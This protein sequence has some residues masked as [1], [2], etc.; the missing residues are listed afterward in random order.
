MVAAGDMKND[1]S[2]I[3]ASTPQMPGRDCMTLG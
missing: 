3:T 2:P 1:G